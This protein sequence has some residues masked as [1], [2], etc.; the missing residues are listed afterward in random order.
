M[1]PFLDEKFKLQRLVSASELVYP[2]LLAGTSHEG[3]QSFDDSKTTTKRNRE[4]ES[5]D[6][7]DQMAGQGCLVYS[8]ESESSGDNATEKKRRR[9]SFRVDENLSVRLEA[10]EE[11]NQ[12]IDSDSDLFEDALAYISSDSDFFSLE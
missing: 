11:E 7:E 6:S 10:S 2:N 4:D 8:F 1:R 9:V 3:E 5:G 12:D